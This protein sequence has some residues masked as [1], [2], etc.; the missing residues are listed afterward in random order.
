METLV[1]GALILIAGIISAIFTKV[2]YAGALKK[3][4]DDA[5]GLQE[6][7]ELCNKALKKESEGHEHTKKTLAEIEKKHSIEIDDINRKKDIDFDDEV[8]SRRR[9]FTD[10]EN[11]KNAEIKNLE[12]N[13][14]STVEKKV[15]KMKEEIRDLTTAK[16]VAIARVEQYEK[17][18]EAMGYDVKNIHEVLIKLVDGLSG[19][20]AS[21]SVEITN[22]TK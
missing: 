8:R 14:T 17:A 6:E 1:M 3:E 9:Q 13:F 12:N 4:Q 2:S 16:D 18:F 10:L 5:K 19:A 22:N 21:K 20:A 15:I 11:D 7:F